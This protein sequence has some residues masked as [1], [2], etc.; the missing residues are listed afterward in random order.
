MKVP[1]WHFQS[2]RHNFLMS[3]PLEVAGLPVYDQ[4]QII[5]PK[6]WS[7]A[8]YFCYYMRK[9]KNSP[10]HPPFLL[11]DLTLEQTESER[12]SPRGKTAEG[13][14]W[15][16]VPRGSVSSPR[17]S[18][19]IQKMKMGLVQDHLASSPDCLFVFLC[20]GRAD[21]FPSH[22]KQF[23][24]HTPVIRSVPFVLSLPGPHCCH[25]SWQR[26]QMLFNERDAQRP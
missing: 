13:R 11:G 19:R 9:Q 3:L 25:I 17:C 22:T 20:V 5:S 21:K 24:P 23:I 26:T 7:W 2:Q 8:F 16:L 4:T 15:N 18:Q 10:N 12:V 1:A 6:S 14:G